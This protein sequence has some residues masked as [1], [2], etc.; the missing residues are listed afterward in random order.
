MKS[1]TIEIDTLDKAERMIE[2]LLCN[3]AKERILKAFEFFPESRDMSHFEIGIF[4]NLARETVCKAMKRIRN[5][6]R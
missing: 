5:Y 3:S 1:E 6:E 2:I 4:V